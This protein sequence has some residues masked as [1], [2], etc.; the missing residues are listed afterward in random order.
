MTGAVVFDHL[1]RLTAPHGLYE[2]ALFA[3][4]R[5]EHG[6]CLDDVARALLVTSREPQPSA[7]VAALAAGYLDFTVRAQSADGRFR[8]RRRPD[9]RW[10]SPPDVGDHWGRAL[11][12]LGTLAATTSDEQVR[13]VAAHAAAHGLGRRSPAWHATAYAVL[14]AVELLRVRPGDRAA[15]GMLHD[16]PRLLLRGRDRPSWPWPDDRLTYANAV[17]P[18]ALLALGAATGDDATTRWGLDLLAWLLA[19]E[20]DGDRLSPT[21]STGRGPG[22]PR[23]GFDQQ[24]IEVTAL[25]EAC[26]RAFELTRDTAWLVALDRCV[27]WFHGDNDLGLPL[28]DP[29]TGA[30]YD[31]LQADRVNG[32]QGAESTLAALATVQLGDLALGRVTR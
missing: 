21:P 5:P 19:Q 20:T 13:D 28:Y 29:R 31:A 12:A 18:E 16:A 27:A 6:H 9:G 23:P 7:R 3:V 30:G 32:N 11:W 22:D 24:P 1:E 17:L 8:N 15:L 2:H 10:T 26:A 14:G 25:A 4:P